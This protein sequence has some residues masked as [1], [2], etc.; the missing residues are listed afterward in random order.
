MR[1]TCKHA[2][3]AFDRLATARGW[4]T[5][6][7]FDDA[8]KVRVGVYSLAETY[9]NCY[10]IEVTVNIAGGVTH[11]FPSWSGAREATVAMDSMRAI[12]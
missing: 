10:T 7:Y 1:Y 9:G 11:P 3:R 8:R 6:P 2:R 5:G 4:D 12:T